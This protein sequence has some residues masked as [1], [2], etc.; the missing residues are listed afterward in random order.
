MANCN[1][2]AHLGLMLNSDKVIKA[3]CKRDPPKVFAQPISVN[4]ALQWTTCTA[5][6]EVPD[7]DNDGCGE[8]QPKGSAPLIA[9]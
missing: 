8:H 9:S 7:P 1:T 6:P 5:R 3:I 4:G 2:C